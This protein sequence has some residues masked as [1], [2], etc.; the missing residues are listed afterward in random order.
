[1]ATGFASIPEAIE[2]IR[3]GKAHPL[4]LL[5][6]FLGLAGMN[7][8]LTLGSSHDNNRYGRLI[9]FFM[10]ITCEKSCFNFNCDGKIKQ[11]R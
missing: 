9:T 10:K 6:N 11:Y 4:D 3:Q 1:M 7:Q 8:R 2:D 5:F